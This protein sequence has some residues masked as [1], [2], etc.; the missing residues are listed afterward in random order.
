MKTTADVP[1]VIAA[2]Y[3]KARRPQAISEA[4]GDG[5]TK[6]KAMQKSSPSQ[7]GLPKSPPKKGAVKM[8]KDRDK[9]AM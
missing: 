7:F 6:V 5:Y 2:E 4:T 8:V 3:S 9:D 1:P